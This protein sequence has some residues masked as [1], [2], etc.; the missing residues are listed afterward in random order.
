MASPR[1]PRVKRSPAGRAT[2]TSPGTNVAWT[3]VR[4]GTGLTVGT[5]GAAA[6]AEVSARSRSSVP[7]ACGSARGG[8]TGTSRRCCGGYGQGST[9]LK[10]AEKHTSEERGLVQLPQAARPALEGVVA[11]AGGGRPGQA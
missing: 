2:T 7:V 6:T 1:R 11:P 3:R 10:D 9:P 8:D 5:R 4:A